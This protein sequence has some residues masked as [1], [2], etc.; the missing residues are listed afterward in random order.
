MFVVKISIAVLLLTKWLVFVVKTSVAMQSLTNLFV[1]IVTISSTLLILVIYRCQP[2]NLHLVIHPK[3]LL[4]AF[5]LA[6]LEYDR[7]QL[8]SVLINPFFNFKT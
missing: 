6:A 8:I 1:I 2:M 4:N 3:A 7:H 5:N